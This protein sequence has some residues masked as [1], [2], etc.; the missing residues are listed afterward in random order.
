[1]PELDPQAA[2]NMRYQ[3]LTT[4]QHAGDIGADAHMVAPARMGLKHRI[5]TGYLVDLDGGSFKY[6]ATASIRSGVR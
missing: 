1:L 4:A 2:L 3:F 6:S 5:K